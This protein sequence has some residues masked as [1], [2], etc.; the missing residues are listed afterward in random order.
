ME[1]DF[2]VDWVNNT[3]N[4]RLKSISQKHWG[5]FKATWA[6]LSQVL[7]LSGMVPPLPRPPL[8]KIYHWQFNQCFI[9]TYQWYLSFRKYQHRLQEFII[10]KISTHP[11]HANHSTNIICWS[12]LTSMSLVSLSS[13]SLGLGDIGLVDLDFKI[14]THPL[15]F[16]EEI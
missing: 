2:K 14:N 7:S 9:V 13:W 15:G 10:Y 1:I 8:W 12:V 3:W 16:G 6:N 5:W 4:I 11:N